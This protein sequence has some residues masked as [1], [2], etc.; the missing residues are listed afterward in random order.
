MG[1]VNIYDTELWEWL[2]NFPNKS[3]VVRES[4]HEYKA[5]HY[6]GVYF[7]EKEAMRDKKK[8]EKQL[9]QAKEKLVKINKLLK[10]KAE[11]DGKEN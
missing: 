4:L 11:G 5:R 9:A 8:Y 1:I 3:D 10:E 6:D 7:S 2:T